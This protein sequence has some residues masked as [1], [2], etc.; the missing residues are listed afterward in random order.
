VTDGATSRSNPDG[1]ADPPATRPILEVDRAGHRP[2][3]LDAACRILLTNDDG[4]GSP[5]L[6]QLA[7]ALAATAQVVVAAPAEDV[8]GAG[9]SIGRYDLDDPTRL[10]AVHDLDGIEAYA[11]DGPPG[12]AVMAAALGAFGPV[13]DLV[14]SGPNAGINT[15]T[16]IVHSGT[17]GAAITARTFGISGVA[18]SL[19]EGEEWHWDTAVAVGRA[20][21]R[22]VLGRA[23]PTTLNVNVPGRPVDRIVGA[24]W[25]EI[26]EFGHFHVAAADTD[27]GV[28]DLEVRD[29]TSGSDP[30]TDTAICLGGEVSLTLLS[31]LG[32]VP[33]PDAAPD[34]VTGVVAGHRR[35]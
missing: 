33:A 29:R 10:R 23:E 1:A 26:D 16:S 19:A 24:R 5:G 3:D 13:P 6:R 8:S 25:G 2:H 32:M 7:A 22:W 17:V 12:L 18:I 28:L 35:S 31:P 20:A 9:T 27:G 4:I 15:G 34:E 30:G 21:V 11:V 14:V